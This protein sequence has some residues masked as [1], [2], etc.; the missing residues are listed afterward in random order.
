[1]ADVRLRGI[2]RVNSAGTPQQSE[3]PEGGEDPGHCLLVAHMYV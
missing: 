3:G 1:M 2:L